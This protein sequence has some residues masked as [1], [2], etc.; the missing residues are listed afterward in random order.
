MIVFCLFNFCGLN[1][2]KMD[3]PEDES[4]GGSETLGNKDN[5]VSIDVMDVNSGVK[6]IIING[7]FV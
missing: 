7:Y 3:Q 6:S 4:H 2:V 5:E 1:L